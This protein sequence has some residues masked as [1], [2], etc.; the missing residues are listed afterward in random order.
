[1]SKVDPKSVW[2]KD[3]DLNRTPHE[4]LKAEDY[5]EISSVS[6]GRKTYYCAHCG[7]TIAKGNSQDVHKFYGNDDWPT[8]RTH[9]KCTEKFIESLRT[10]EDG[11]GED[12]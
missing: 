4:Y 7:G 1:M 5:Y 11:P 8:Y 2:D 10:E 3:P 12:Y 9:K 6:S